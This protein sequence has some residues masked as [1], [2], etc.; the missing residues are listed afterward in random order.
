MKKKKLINVSL[1]NV[2]L[3]SLDRANRAVVIKVK[4]EPQVSNSKVRIFASLIREEGL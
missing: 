3:F 4:L 1:F 2:L